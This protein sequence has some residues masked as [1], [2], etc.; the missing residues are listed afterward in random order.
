MFSLE[1]LWAAH[2]KRV[3]S[4]LLVAVMLVGLTPVYALETEAGLELKAESEGPYLVG[5]DVAVR[6]VA[7]N[8]A[9]IFYAIDEAPTEQSSKIDGD[10]ITV[11]SD[12]AGIV[13]L[14]VLAVVESEIA[15]DSGVS[16]EEQQAVEIQGGQGSAGSDSQTAD[17]VQDGQGSAGNNS[18]TADEAQDGQ[19]SAGNDSQT[20]DEAQNGQGSAGSDSQTAD[21][22]QD[23]QG[24]AGNDSQTADEV[25]DGQGSA[26]NDSQNTEAEKTKT[27]S[28]DDDETISGKSHVS[29]N[30]GSE[31]LMASSLLRS[32]SMGMSAVAQTGI[33]TLGDD[34]GDDADPSKNEGVFTSKEK[35]YYTASLQLEFIEMPNVMVLAASA[36]DAPVLGLTDA[37]KV[38]SFDESAEITVT[39]PDGAT[40]AY[41]T[42]D[43]SDPTA[44]S[45][46]V[47][48][49]TIKVTAP[50]PETNG[51]TVMIKVA[52]AYSSNGE[53]NLA[54]AAEISVSFYDGAKA[55][56]DVA[57]LEIDGTATYYFSNSADAFEAVRTDSNLEGEVT[58][59]VLE[60]AQYSV[61]TTNSKGTVCAFFSGYT[62]KISEWTLDL[63][64]KDL[65]LTSSS[66][67]NINFYITTTAIQS[68]G[69]IDSTA[70]G[71]PVENG[72]VKE[73]F[74]GG[75]L[76]LDN[77]R[78]YVATIP[79]IIVDGVTVTGNIEQKFLVNFLT[80]TT[81]R[82]SVF[83]GNCTEAAV[84]CNN[85]QVSN[86][87]IKN[88][89]SGYGFQQ[90][91]TISNCVITAEN[92]AAMYLMSARGVSVTGG[93]YTGTTAVKTESSVTL[94]SGIF[95]GGF[96][97]SG[98]ITISGTECYYKGEWTAKKDITGYEEYTVDSGEYT[99]YKSFRSIG[100][101]AIV[102]SIVEK[103]TGTSLPSAAS[104]TALGEDGETLTD[105]S[106]LLEGT[107]IT[108]KLTAKQDYKFTGKVMYA[109]SE[110]SV[111]NPEETDTNKVSI[112]DDGKVLTYIDTVPNSD[113]WLQFE[114]E[115]IGTN[116]EPIVQIGDTTYTSITTALSALDDSE[117][118]VLLKDTTYSDAMEFNKENV[119][120]DLNGKTL[121]LDVTAQSSN[122]AK[123]YSILVSGGSLTVKDDVGSGRISFN[124]NHISGFLV[125]GE[126]TQLN[127]TSG[128]YN[129]LSTM[130]AAYT[131]VCSAENGRVNFSGGTIEGRIYVDNATCELT[132]S[133][134]AT[135]NTKDYGMA[136]ALFY[137]KINITGGK[138]YADPASSVGTEL[139]VINIIDG[140]FEM[141]GGDI[142]AEGS[143]PALYIQNTSTRNVRSVKIS[144]NAAIS[145]ENSAAISIIGDS[146][147]GNAKNNSVEISGS[148]KIKG[149]T[150]ALEIEKNPK[151]QLPSI[152]INGGYFACGNGG[153]PISD[154]YYV[155]YPDT[156]NDGIPDLVLDTEESETVTGYY[157]LVDPDTLGGTYVPSEGTGQKP[158]DYTYQD[159]DGI[160]DGS[161]QGLNQVLEMA[162][163][164]YDAGNSANT[165]PGDAWSTFTSAYEL[166]ERCVTNKNANQVEINYRA[167]ALSSALIELT[168]AADIDPATM[169]DGTYKIQVGL[170]KSDMTT[171]SMSNGAVD[172]IATLVK[173][174]TNYDLSM[175]FGPT[176]QYTV[177][178]HLEDFFIY[179]G[180]DVNDAKRN[181]QAD[182][183]NGQNQALAT[184]ANYSNWYAGSSTSDKKEMAP[185]GIGG[186]EHET[187]NLPG[188]V[189]V[190]LP[191]IG[192]ADD[193]RSYWVGMNVDAMGGFASAILML[194]W[195]TLEAVT[196]TSTLDVNTST[197]ELIPKQEFQ[198]KASVLNEEG[199]NIAYESN[200]TAI[201]TVNDSGKVTAV[202]TA[203][204]GQTCTITVTASKE[205]NDDVTRTVSIKIKS[206]TTAA[207]ASTSTNGTTASV[208]I[209]GDAVV[210]G[211]ETVIITDTQIT[212]NAEATLGG[213]G[214]K[215]VEISFAAETMTALAAEEKSV[216]IV[217]DVGTITLDSDAASSAANSG[218]EIKLTMNEVDAP[219]I[220]GLDD[221]DFDAAYELTMRYGSSSCSNLGGDVTI[222]VPWSGSVGYAYYVDGD[223]LAERYTMTIGSSTASWVTD[224]FSTWALSTD[225]NL[226]EVGITE[227]VYSVP[228][229]IKQADAPSR[230]SMANDATGDMVVADVDEDGVTYT[231]FL[232][233]RIGDEM[234]GDSLRGHLLKMWYYA[235]DDTSLSNP[236][237]ATVVRTYQDKDM[238]GEIDTFPREVEVYQEGDPNE[239]YY[240]QVSV[241]AMGG[242]SALQNALVKL[243]WD[244]ALD[245]GGEAAREGF[246]D[247]Y[248]TE[249]VIDSGDSVSRSDLKDWIDNECILLVQGRD[250]DLTA[251][252][253]T[254]ALEDIYGQT[255]SSVKFVLEELKKS[256]LSDEQQEVAGDRPIYQLKITSGSKTITEIDDGNV[257]VTFPFELEED[258]VKEGLLIQLVDDDGDVQKIKCS[259]STKGETVSFDTTNFGIF[260]IGYDAEQIWENPFTDVKE[261][262]WFYEAVK[263]VVQ[264][265]LFAGTSETT[266]EPNLTMTR[267]MLVTVLYRLAGSP[268][269]EGTSKFSDVAPNAYYTDAVIW[270]TQN[271]IVG[272]Y[273]NGLFGTT[274][275]ISREQMATI[276]YRYAQ[277]MEYD[278]S[279][280]KGLNDY[281]DSNQVSSYAVRAMQWAVANEIIYGTSSTTL[282]PQG[283][284]TRSQVAVI[285]MRFDEEIA[286]PA[287]QQKEEGTKTK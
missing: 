218:Q 95:D 24:S 164:F 33:S 9:T 125:S 30:Y 185:D 183:Q 25:Q 111:S 231:M 1:R 181:M 138:I 178:G 63:N 29:N 34:E 221:S 87:V 158:Q 50:Q 40:G 61:P 205:G 94:N 72:K 184:E 148:A 59:K 83:T 161:N 74:S 256:E 14:N 96:I 121:T 283:S 217:T 170:W 236:I 213:S 179:L 253:D 20:A 229:V 102:A 266:F 81:I 212:I 93:S 156:D 210:S 206:G 242:D 233:A 159:Y 101:H 116:Q 114:V 133:D 188:T 2:S 235:P 53:T 10:S 230:D 286:V 154:T 187:Y 199:W 153:L 197:L 228:I 155:T 52:A 171:P 254:D 68:F 55:D 182:T 80:D 144:E 71:T 194:Q 157:G 104:I 227:G 143:A 3:L 211:S 255:S 49:N 113:L 91:T 272:G 222:T 226:M 112:S 208:A 234:G 237:R 200:N 141:S 5:D 191:Y 151:E 127:I 89:G 216:A 15:V 26:G 130:A 23:S 279:L 251:Y 190:R 220:D 269:V 186:K 196:T 249:Q 163:D 259:Y 117:T 177:Y 262:D 124:K 70:T 195:G 82:N 193:T 145:S 149:A 28:T 13:T 92:N 76:V 169:P 99:G 165:Y 264:K 78:I 239:E 203:T 51:G 274:D 224:H 267:S 270:A 110:A 241:D 225:R 47:V 56:G 12:K 79:E 282:S 146:G 207:S 189:T 46:P 75:E 11:T 214:V 132:L 160:S 39:L 137:G 64:G 252:F 215:N 202:E 58:L 37:K 69:I 176:Y 209:S 275:P 134:N 240:I 278:V 106:N 204:A 119:T 57:S 276:L 98:T 88:T 122:L 142:A 135:L 54:Q 109:D 16:Q 62:P 8:G 45:F 43:G 285:L 128:T 201:A 120:L 21:E 175:N 105:L 150:Y 32:A 129:D 174:G 107:E 66:G 152:Q 84:E 41:Y 260:V 108:W 192:T 131:I 86:C 17:E 6:V 97:G 232:K 36:L 19:E 268:E 60:D 250:S 147:I 18:Q 35:K 65:T 100:K 273:D 90:A 126:E 44:S 277:H 67:E 263:Y 172:P 162:K 166:A 261:E 140:S 73:D 38:Y 257:E 238:Y 244:N 85:A 223:E 245:D 284:A 247:E 31:M 22:V 198:L 271:G 27:G 248:A 243:D 168:A 123:S 115:F 139:G 246:E 180:D 77:V 280:V 281:T 136:I 4:L 48:D 173:E 118:L 7:P 219:D 287:E 42:V 265:G 103:G 167:A 258:E